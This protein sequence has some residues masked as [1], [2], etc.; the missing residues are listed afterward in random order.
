MIPAHVG[1]GGQ[2]EQGQE[3][4]RM[5]KLREQECALACGWSVTSGIV[6]V[7]RG[8]KGSFTDLRF[9]GHLQPG[10]GTGGGMAYMCQGLVLGRERKEAGLQTEDLPI[11]NTG[12]LQVPASPTLAAHMAPAGLFNS[13]S[14]LPPIQSPYSRQKAA[15]FL[16]WRIPLH[17]TNLQ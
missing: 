13:L 12:Q 2:G 6:E 16:G 10:E 15:A 1:A 8:N 17:L 3:A 5:P 14:Q 11:E 7:S 9:R 4:P